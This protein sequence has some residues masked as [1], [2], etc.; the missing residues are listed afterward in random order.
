MAVRVCEQSTHCCLREG[1]SMGLVWEL[2]KRLALVQ[3]LLLPLLSSNDQ[4]VMTVVCFDHSSHNFPTDF[5]FGTASSSYQYEGAYLSDGKG[6]GNW[7]VFSHIPGKIIDA[8]NGDIAV[9]HYHRYLEDIE[10]MDA[11]KVNSY[12][13]SLSWARI[14]PKGK[15]GEVNLA[16][17]DFY[18]RLID[19]LLLKGIQPFVTLTHFDMPQELEDKYGGWLSPQSQEDF[20]FYAELCF[21]WFGERVTHWTTFNEP[22]LLVSFSYRTGN[23]PPS[24]CSKPFGDCIE[25]D[26]E[27]EPFIAA[28]NI[29]LSH[30]AAVDIYK[31]KYQR[32]QKGR[33]GIVLKAAWYEPVS[34]STTDIMAS[35]RALSFTFNW[36]LDPIVFGKYPSEMEKILGAILPKFSSIEMVKLQR[37]LDYIGINYYTSYYVQDCISSAC[38]PGEGITRTEGL[39]RKSTEKNGVPIGEPTTIGWCVYPRGMEKVITHVKD[40]YNNIPM[41]I[42]ENGYGETDHPNSTLE[43]HIND[44]KRMKY[45]EDHLNAL[46]SATRKGAD[47]RGYFAWSLLDNFQWEYGYTRRFGLYHIDFSTLKRTQKLSASWYKQFIT[48]YKRE[49]FR[50]EHDREEGN[51]YKQFRTSAKVKSFV[52]KPNQLRFNNM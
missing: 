28:H 52:P 18:N 50:P 15:F 25:G 17:I 40:R 21:K 6:L 12:R 26:S 49:A 29:I 24:R 48:K 4:K 30:A 31:T 7:D 36:F 47:V 9:D 22:N 37:G 32:E 33:I 46:V 10:L 42:T 16:G 34:N 51:R 11:I 43:E 27:S 2:V 8:S 45:M 35:Q 19:A 39:Y 44:V 23:F 1:I 13:F 20:A 41:F 38:E 5:L 14:L 3:I